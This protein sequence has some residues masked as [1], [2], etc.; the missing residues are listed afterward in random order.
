MIAEPLPAAADA[1]HV[2]DV[3]RRAGVLDDCRVSDVRVASSR[4]T[5]LSRI[6]R[7]RLTY[8]NATPHAPSSIILKTGLPDRVDKT[9][10]SGRQEV[11]FYENVGRATPAGLVPLCFEAA[12]DEATNAWHLLLEDLTETHTT[13][14]RWPLPPSKPQCEQIVNAWARFHAAWWD[15][16]RL[17]HSVGTW[18]SER[19]DA[20]ALQRLFADR[21]HP[22]ADRL[23]DRLPQERRDLYERFLDAV[24][25]L[26]ERYRSHRN[27][28]IIH[29]DAHVWN[30]FLP[31]DESSDGT[32]L[33]DWDSW[34][35]GM[36]A[37]DLAY[38]MA[39]H[40]CPDRRRQL[41]RPLI[42]RYHAALLAQ[43]VAGYDRCA[44]DD[45]YRLS[46]LFLIMRPVNQEAFDIPPVIWWNNLE[47]ILLAVDDLGCG[48]L[49]HV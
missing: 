44:L 23:G 3:L 27:L 20:A 1:E 28:T 8:D 34:R 47:R 7:L 4:A 36:A 6:I 42:D 12:W 22:F 43:G 26:W 45:D 30:C 49:L 46:A 9:W 25:R 15:D 18:T 38:M 29:G 14:T 39:M 24:P 32:R 31:Q 41:E 21:Y 11:A 10:A 48:D 17:G 40:W 35:I 19:E 33:F 37:A 5:I 2:T 16:P 13:P